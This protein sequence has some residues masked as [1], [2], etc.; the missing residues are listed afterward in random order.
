MA[1]FPEMGQRTKGEG[2]GVDGHLP[3]CKVGVLRML[4][5]FVRSVTTDEAE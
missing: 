1:V 5:D 4:L 3:N 2:I